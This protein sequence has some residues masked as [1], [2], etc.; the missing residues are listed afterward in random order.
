MYTVEI[1]YY[2]IS[3]RSVY[4]TDHPCTLEEARC[5]QQDGVLP[6]VTL[7]LSPPPQPAPETLNHRTPARSFF[8]QD[9]EA[10]KLAYKASLKVLY[11]NNMFKLHITI[12][13]NYEN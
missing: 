5:L 2:Y 1:N 12:C 8:E 7:V 4:D 6:T 11:I 13:T 3:N 10:L 9:F